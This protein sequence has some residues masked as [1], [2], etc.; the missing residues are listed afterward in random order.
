VV[1]GQVIIVISFV[2]ITCLMLATFFV[3]LKS[4][5]IHFNTD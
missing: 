2:T 4:G 3:V 1:V 5:A